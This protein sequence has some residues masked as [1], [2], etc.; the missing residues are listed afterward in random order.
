MD[1]YLP[2][3]Y[4]TGLS[5]PPWNSSPLFVFHDTDGGEESVHGERVVETN[6]WRA[7]LSFS[8][9]CSQPLGAEPG[10]Q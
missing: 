1:F 8:F 10:S 3:G 7:G 2:P 5:G 9:L 6:T 4:M